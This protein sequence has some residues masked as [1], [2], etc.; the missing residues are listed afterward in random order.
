M[1]A[2]SGRPV[3]VFGLVV[4]LGI[5]IWAVAT[6][7]I[8]PDPTFVTERACADDSGFSCVVLNVPRDHFDEESRTWEVSFAIQRASGEKQ[9]VIVVAT[10]GPGTSGIS[11]ADLYTSYFPTAVVE[12]YD[13]VFF[14]QRGINRS[15][16]LQC[17]QASLEWYT[18]PQLPTGSAPDRAAFRTATEQYVADCIDEAGV[19]PDD[20]ALYSTEQAIE[21]LEVFRRW[22]GADRLILYGESYGTQFVQAYAAAHPDHVQALIIDGPVDMTSQ[23]TDYY[24]ETAQTDEE[25]LQL[26]LEDCDDDPACAADLGGSAALHVYDRWATELGEGPIEFD[27]VTDDGTVVTRHMTR[28]DYE[29]AIE[30]VLTPEADRMF[31]QRALAQ[32]SHGELLPLARLL[33]AAL[34][35]DPETLKAVPDPSWSDALYF[36]V[37][38]SDYAFGTGTPDER[39][40]QYFADGEAAG[41]NDL[42][43]GSGYY[44]DLPCAWWP[45]HGPEERP[46]YLG[47]TPYPIFILGATWDPATPYAN[48]ERLAA[49]LTNS[50]SIIQPGGPHVI[51]LRGL[52][53]PDDQIT[54][55]LLDGELPAERYQECPF[56]GVEPY[57]PIP[58]ADAGDYASTLDALS[59]VDDEI[60]YNPDWWYW[61][62][63]GTLSF[64]CLH[65]GTISYTA[66]DTEYDLELDDC[67]FSQGLALSGTGVIHEDYTIDLD[68]TTAGG[69]ALTYARDNADHRTATG[70][71]D[72]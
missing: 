14:D 41:V 59:A 22:H 31:L 34:G 29:A 11:V 62:G 37:D 71:L 42:R 26:I 5:G 52:H 66:S 64:G 47:D 36:A 32:A 12:G 16:P 63:E 35:Q 33:Y 58:A 24:V 1:S 8:A 28:N 40:D 20:L 23:G 2:L 4:A 17:I 18:T 56:S 21:D 57:V 65:G 48:A 61:E 27:F 55:Y 70:T 39:A 10:G 60:S 46:P 72:P 38:C 3:L 43:L 49:N 15:Q 51:Y 45:T 53:C 68:L 30:Y 69:S 44:L 67:A 13:I 9:G 54:A 50:Y 25:V 6:A 19:D 7:L